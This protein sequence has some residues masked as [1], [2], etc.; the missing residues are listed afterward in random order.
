[1]A[2]AD[3]PFK[4]NNAAT[5]QIDPRLV[6]QLK[7]VT[8]QG[9][10]QRRLKLDQAVRLQVDALVV[11]VEAAAALP[12]GLQHRQV[13]VQQQ[14]VDRLTALGI[15]RD[16]DAAAHQQAFV[17]DGKRLGQLVDDFLGDLQQVAG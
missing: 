11:E 8:A 1:M 12:L 5:A 7:L 4:A 3:Q 10:T 15:G 9:L 6:V 13:G 17:A 2:P 16:T 14:T